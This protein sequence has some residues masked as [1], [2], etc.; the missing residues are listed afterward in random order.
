MN[1]RLHSQLCQLCMLHI[2][3]SALR[4]AVQEAMRVDAW[5][6]AMDVIKWFALVKDTK[7]NSLGF[8]Y[9]IVGTGRQASYLSLLFRSCLK[10]QFAQIPFPYLIFVRSSMRANN[11]IQLNRIRTYI[12]KIVILFWPC[13][14]PSTR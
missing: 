8:L 2:L 6:G 10:S 1:I 9:A 4:I 3:S 7:E 14:S 5:P 12:S 13:N 11:Q